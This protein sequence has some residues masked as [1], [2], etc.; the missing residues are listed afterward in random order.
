MNAKEREQFYDEKI[1][2]DLLRLGKLCQDNGLSF[3]AGVEWDPDEV[4]RTA[5]LT[6]NAGEGIRRANAALQG[7]FGVGMVALTV[8]EKAAPR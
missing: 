5:A 1:A 3:V 8:T 4:G 2:P 7:E 6:K